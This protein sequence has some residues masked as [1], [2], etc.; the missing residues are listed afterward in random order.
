L[1]RAIGFHLRIACVAAFSTFLAAPLIAASIFVTGTADTIANDGVCTLREAITSANNG[2]NFSDC[3]PTGATPYGTND[4]IGFDIVPASDT[5]C[6]VATGVCT[7]EPTTGLPQ[8][9]KTMLIDGYTQAGSAP[10]TLAGIDYPNAQ[11]LDTTIK[12]EL[13]GSLAGNADG[14]VLS[15]PGSSRIRGLSIVGFSAAVFVYS[16]NNA[17]A[18]NFIGVRAD[19]TSAVANNF[20]VRIQGPFGGSTVIGVS[21]SPAAADRNLIA[22]STSADVLTSSS[23]ANRVAGNLIGTDT[24]GTSPRDTNVGVQ[25]GGGT[26]NDVVGNLIAG[27][28]GTGY[29]VSLVGATNSGIVNNSIGLAVGGTP[30]GSLQY[31]VYVVLGGAQNNSIRNNGIA[32]N[33]ADGIVVLGDAVNGDPI[34]NILSDNA[35]HSNGGLGINLSASEPFLSTPTLNDSPAALDADT[36]PNRLQNYPVIT[37]ATIN[38]SGGIDIAFTLD[39]AASNDYRISAYSNDV[40]DASGY[41]EGRYPSGVA[42]PPLYTTNAAGHT[43]GTFTVPAPLPAGWGAGQVVTLLARDAN[44]SDT[45]EF[46]LCATVTGAPDT[47]PNPFTFVDETGAALST[48]S[49]SASIT[50][51]GINTPAAISVSGGEYRVNG[52]AFVSSAGIVNNGDLVEARV[53]S[54]ASYSA[55]VSAVVTIGG[56]DDSYDVTTDVAPPSGSSDSFSGPTGTASGTQTV[57]FNSTTGGCTFQSHLFSVPALVT[58]PPAGWS[59]PHGVVDFTIASCAANGAAVTLTLTYPQAL[60]AGSVYWKYGPQ[61]SGGPNV[62]YQL[63]GVV[64]NGNQVTFT[65][66][67]G[68]I[69]DDDWIANGTIADAGGPA[70]PVAAA[71]VPIPTLDEWALIALSALLAVLG[72]R[73]M[74]VVR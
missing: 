17:I 43:T 33:G 67:D 3:V 2:A 9:D 31:G 30:L 53:M 41:G 68:L 45:S 16:N 24:S 6:V 56:I 49:V 38:G 72:L 50:V 51:S 27:T 8:I 25:I 47:T 36:G 4:T 14:F 70:F 5:G 69:G 74:H 34:G 37:S 13:D 10:N 60:P 42:S 32:H 61:T 44:T 20:G 21:A 66:T 46:S 73:G 40:C 28:G 63:P 7:I 18:G 12:I 59:F 26:S 19:G 23:N 52:G 58:N 48:L 54:S 55:T 65:L 71:A 1:I 15:G 57:G 35:I 39:S 64:I 11:A 22:A 29:G 62:W